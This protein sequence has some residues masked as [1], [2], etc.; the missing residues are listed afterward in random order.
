VKVISFSV[1]LMSKWVAKDGSEYEFWK[2]I[3]YFY[4]L[5]ELVPTQKH[6]NHSIM[7]KWDESYEDYYF[8]GHEDRKTCKVVF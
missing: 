2:K 3:D 8:A 5:G 6:L 1:F 4:W 7:K